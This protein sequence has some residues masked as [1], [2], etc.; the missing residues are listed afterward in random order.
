MDQGR[1]TLTRRIGESITIGPDI[2]IRILDVRGCQVKLQI[3]APKVVRIFRTELV[4]D[5]HE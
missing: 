2:I 4:E 3:E 5:S 1:L